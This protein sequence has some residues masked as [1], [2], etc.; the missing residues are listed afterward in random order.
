MTTPMTEPIFV[1]VNESAR[2]LGL[3]K[4]SIYDLLNKQLIESSYHGTK[5]LVR[6]ASLVA[7]AAGLP[8]EAPS[9]AEAATSG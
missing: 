2:I 9:E 1:D 5:R 3:S 8:T 7:Y 6:Y 4:W